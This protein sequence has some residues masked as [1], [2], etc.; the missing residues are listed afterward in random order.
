MAATPTE[1]SSLHRL[2]IIVLD[3]ATSALD[4]QS[5]DALMRVLTEELRPTTIVS[6]AHRPQLEA[7]HSRRIVLERRPGG[8]RFVIDVELA[9]RR[10]RR[11]RWGSRP[12]GRHARTRTRRRQGTAEC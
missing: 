6:V 2:D 3:E 10:D 1:R 7:F 4:P 12:R 9:Q 8:A 5:Q 11:E